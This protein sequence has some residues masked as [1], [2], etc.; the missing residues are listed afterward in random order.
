MTTAAV[1]PWCLA[2]Q[3]CIWVQGLADLMWHFCCGH[4]RAARAVA[5]AWVRCC[6]CLDASQTTAR[7]GPGYHV[8]G[9]PGYVI[10]KYSLP[11][12]QVG[13]RL[14]VDGTLMGIDHEAHTLLPT[15]KRGNFRCAALRSR[16]V[17]VAAAPWSKSRA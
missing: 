3:Q 15:W 7:W 4:M 6:R 11:R 17:P 10:K 2:S 1:R 16:C 5:A 14:R 8:L 9:A 13:T 12:L